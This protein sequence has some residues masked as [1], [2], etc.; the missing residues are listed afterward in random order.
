MFSPLLF[1]LRLKLFFRKFMRWLNIFT[2]IINCF[3]LGFP[4]D[5]VYLLRRFLYEC[6][7][8]SA[9]YG[10]RVTSVETWVW[11]FVIVGGDIYVFGLKS[12]IALYNYNLLNRYLMLKHPILWLM[13]REL[14]LLKRLEYVVFPRAGLESAPCGLDDIAR[15]RISRR[16][17]YYPF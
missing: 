8:S 14:L 4:K 7:E 12:S 13:A 16:A 15:L 17:S 1:L 10:A 11:Q 2:I 6:F 3:T 9:I 5:W